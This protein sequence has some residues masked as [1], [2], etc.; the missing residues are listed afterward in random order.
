M[1]EA[2]KGTD[3]TGKFSFLR[4]L[5]RRLVFQELERVPPPEGQTEPTERLNVSFEAQVGVALNT[6]QRIAEV[7]LQ[8]LVRPDPMWRP[9]SVEVHLSGIFSAS[10]E[11]SIEAL[12]RFAQTNAPVIL[13]PYVREAV[14]RATMDGTY[15]ALLLDPVNLSSLLA[16]NAWHTEAAEP[17]EAK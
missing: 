16:S 1:P 12:Q 6:E 14:H 10:A 7:R 11:T 13:W 3:L 15:G 17:A 2:A 9:Y 8:A 5:V 4:V